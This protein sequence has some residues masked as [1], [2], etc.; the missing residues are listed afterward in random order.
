MLP[1]FPDTPVFKL[2]A[3]PIPAGCDA[4]TPAGVYLSHQEEGGDGGRGIWVSRKN[5]GYESRFK[6]NDR[7]KSWE[8]NFPLALATGNYIPS[9]TGHFLDWGGETGLMF[10]AFIG[11]GG[12]VR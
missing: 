1:K 4:L 11:G 8:W 10:F 7:V 5:L 9:S 6:R 3:A 12:E 2:Y